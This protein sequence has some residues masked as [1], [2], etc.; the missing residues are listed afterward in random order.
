MRRVGERAAHVDL[1]GEV[2]DRLGRDGDHELGERG[3][4]AHVGALE[5]G[6]RRERAGEVRL[7]AAG[8]VVDDRHRIAAREQR[9]DEMRAD[10]TGA[11]GDERL[12]AA[13]V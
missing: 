13:R 11:A 10:E 5:P 7:A 12:H 3:A 8:E 1:G 4:V 2:E 9:V 6:A